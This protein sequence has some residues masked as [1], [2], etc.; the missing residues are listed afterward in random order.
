MD[1]SGF[2]PDGDGM[3][4]GSI[5]LL[6]SQGDPSAVIWRIITKDIDSI[7]CQAVVVTAFFRPGLKGFKGIPRCVDA[8]TSATVIGIAGGVG[9]ITTVTHVIV[10]TIQPGSP[11]SMLSVSFTCDSRINTVAAGSSITAAKMTTADS[12]NPSAIALAQPAG[13][14]IRII[15]RS[16]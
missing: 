2:I 7:N 12:D 6:F 9:I 3:A 15:L 8:N 16:G 14:A 5:P 1:G 4:A 11:H 10:D 13:I